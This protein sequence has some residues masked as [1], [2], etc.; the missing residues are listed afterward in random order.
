MEDFPG[1]T[2]GSRVTNTFD[3]QL[4]VPLDHVGDPTNDPF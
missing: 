4:Q 3:H 1:S 2:N